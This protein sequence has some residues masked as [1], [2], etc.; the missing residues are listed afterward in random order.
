M[1]AASF[2]SAETALRAHQH[3]L[4][5]GD[6]LIA[7][8]G[9][10][11][12]V[13]RVRTSEPL[14]LNQRVGRFEVTDPH[15]LD[16]GF[17]FYWLRADSSKDQFVGLAYGSAQPNLS[18]ASIGSVNIVLPPLPEQQA[19][20]EVLGSLDDKIAANTK[21]AATADSV[22][23]TIL[24]LSLSG[25]WARLADIAVIT[26]GSSP[27]GEALN[28]IGEGVPFYQGVRDFGMRAPTRRVFTTG[29]VR[30]AAQGDVLV[31]VR[32]P[33]GDVNLADE[34]LCIGRGIA[35]VRSANDTQSTL[36]HQLRSERAAWEPFEA[37]GTVFGSI[38]RGQLHG[39][40]LRTVKGE[41]VQ[42]I[43]DE[44]MTVEA[45]I[46]K[47]LEENRTLA[48]TRDALLP[49]LMSGKLRVREAENLAR[50]SGL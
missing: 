34:A 8:T 14:L 1:T 15:S 26:M 13:A 11:G 2:V 22:A 3:V 33:V 30:M 41:L 35:A 29:P 24:L 28:E 21:L 47:L 16:P 4:S 23:S 39:I 20:A 5:V 27:K 31:S 12:E 18:P 7:M 37:E 19:I 9:Y 48:A 25:E 32:A 45:A 46:S 50:E 6:I 10:V 49:Q 42:R 43:E 44:L 38:N 17:L 36:F 40:R